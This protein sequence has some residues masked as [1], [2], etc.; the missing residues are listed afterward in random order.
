M[1]M[2]K[3]LFEIYICRES[4]WGGEIHVKITYDDIGY[5][6]VV[7]FID[8]NNKYSAIYFRSEYNF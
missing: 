7:Y 3:C 1:S 2:L 5:Y 8:P 6:V 4:M